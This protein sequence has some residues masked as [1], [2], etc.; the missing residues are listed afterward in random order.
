MVPVLALEKIIVKLDRHYNYQK[1][2]LSLESLSS[3]ES[4]LSHESLPSHESL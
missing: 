1:S 2:P 4:L 3:L